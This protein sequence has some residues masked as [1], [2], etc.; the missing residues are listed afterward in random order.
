MIT[1]RKWVYS[2]GKTLHRKQQE[3]SSKT[4]TVSSL[5]PS[6]QSNFSS[7]Q[8]VTESGFTKL[9]RNQ[10]ESC[11]HIHSMHRKCPTTNGSSNISLFDSDRLD[12]KCHPNMLLGKITEIENHYPGVVT[13]DLRSYE[14]NFCNCVKK[15]QQFRTST[16][17][18]PVTS[19]YRCD[20]LT[21]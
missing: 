13:P 21:N 19:R 7:E 17:F 9:C 20:A 14:R 18:E 5:V 8:Q 11:Q 12:V 1:R 2:N 4:G 16:G 15:P 10:P 6:T 3:S